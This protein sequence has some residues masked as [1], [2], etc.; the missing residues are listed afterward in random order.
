LLVL[1]GGLAALFATASRSPGSRLVERITFQSFVFPTSCKPTPLGI[2]CKTHAQ[3]E[4]VRARFA[5]YHVSLPVDGKTVALPVPF[6]APTSP[7]AP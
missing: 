3:A 1:C 2:D 7:S 4:R 5:K 6:P